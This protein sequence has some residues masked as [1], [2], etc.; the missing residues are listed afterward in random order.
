[1]YR[2]EI[3]EAADG[4]A[5]GRGARAHADA[6]RACAEELRGGESL[7]AL[8]RGLGKVEAPADFE[9]RLRAR[10]AN[11]GT[12]GRRTPLRGL[13][14]VY[15]FAP[16][17]AAA[18]FLVVITALY[19]RQESRTNTTE[20][21]TVAVSAPARKAG[22]GQ[23][24]TPLAGR[25][26]EGPKETGV[27]G[28]EVALNRTASPA[29]QAVQRSRAA[30]RQSAAKTDSRA[31]VQRDTSD[32]SFSQAPVVYGRGVTIAVKASAEPMRMIL[33]DER[34]AGRVVPM[35]SVSFGA[36]EL[37]TREGVGRQATAAEDE[38]V[39]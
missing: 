26:V 23:S 14:L 22:A 11:A 5:L 25:P 10:M 28:V 4:D 12:P 27:R 15:A 33:R 17:A 20:A 37:I 21:P 18:C 36:Q 8:V 9:Y 19:V 24:I 34:G 35:R 16:V 2:R 38:G 29:R 32:F 31:A 3:V 30:T 39:W 7:R 1:V 13:R 6:C